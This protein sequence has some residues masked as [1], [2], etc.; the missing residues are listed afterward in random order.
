M[1]PYSQQGMLTPTQFEM[2]RVKGLGDINGHVR[3]VM[4]AMSL[5]NRFQW[6]TLDMGREEV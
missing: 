3:H 6:D 2:S 1:L 5:F 4:A